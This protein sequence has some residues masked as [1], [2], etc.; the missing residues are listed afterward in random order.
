MFAICSFMSIQGID[1]SV[2][3]RA[4]GKNSPSYWTDNEIA[5][6][7]KA[8]PVLLKIVNGQR[9]TDSQV[10][11]IHQAMKQLEKKEQEMQRKGII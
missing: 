1:L 3:E 5:E 9:R 6:I 7:H 8:L 4:A 10:H 11:R 2:I